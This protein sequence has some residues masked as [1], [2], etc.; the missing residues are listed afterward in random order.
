MD[1]KSIDFDPVWISVAAT[2][3]ACE[4]VDQLPSIIATTIAPYTNRSSYL[5]NC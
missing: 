4:A 5:T 1:V 3:F 2:F